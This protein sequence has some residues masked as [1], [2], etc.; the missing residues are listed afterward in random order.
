MVERDIV[1]DRMKIEYEGLF[2][3]RELYKLIDNWFFEKGYDK[4]EKQSSEIIKPTGKYV[5]MEFE[6][7]KKVT[8]YAKNVIWIR[9]IME[10]VKEVEIEKDG[11]KVKLNQGKV[12]I[13][14][15]G[16]LETD[17]EHRWEGKPI[18]YFIRVIFDKYLYK[19]FTMGFKQGVKED[20]VHLHT[21]IKAFL[22]LY[23]Y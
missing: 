18:F 6:P 16:F 11:A 20:V 13:V 21:Q 17:Y 8:D 2:S 10:D 14:F 9:L 22:N 1:V 15:K 12:H 7:W 3:A 4:R 23:R 5:E 19:P